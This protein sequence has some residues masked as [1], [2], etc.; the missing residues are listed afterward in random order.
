MR[1]F[2]RRATGPATPAAGSVRAPRLFRAMNSSRGTMMGDAI[3]LTRSSA[4]RRRGLLGIDRLAVGEGLWID[5]CEGV[6]TFG[7][8]F[9]I[10]VIFLAGNH[11]VVKTVTMLPPRRISV[12]WRAK[13]LLELPAGT[14]DRCCVKPGDIIEITLP[15]AP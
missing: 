9:T 11:T 12:C 3:W 8:R 15:D 7:M 10:D 14:I 1:I 5:P 6:H 13:S 2:A 4:E